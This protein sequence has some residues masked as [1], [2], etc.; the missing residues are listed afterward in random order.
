MKNIVH[1]DTRRYW[2]LREKLLTHPKHILYK[3]WLRKI[4]AIQ[5]KYL[6]TVPLQSHIG[7]GITLPH[8]LMGIFISKGAVIGERCT[9]FQQVTIGSNMTENSKHKGS[10]I[11]GDDVFIGAN[12][13]IIGGIKIGNRVKI[14]A[15]CT[16][17]E[18][19]PDD[20]TV[21][22]DKPRILLKNNI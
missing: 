2:K 7:G 12:A 10:P 19:V 18:D 13:I 14:G 17:F 11:I 9:I 5:R 6:C 20:A 21:V 4:Y 1:N 15:G 22:C 8:G 3:Y 16:V